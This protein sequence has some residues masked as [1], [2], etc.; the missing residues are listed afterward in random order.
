MTS[1]PVGG[2]GGAHSAAAIGEQPLV[3]GFALAGAEVFEVSD[4]EGARAAWAALSP[5]VSVVVLTPTAARALE[6]ERAR[7]DAPLTVVMP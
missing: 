7:P 1:G 3:S 6:A 5:A 4:V 2:A